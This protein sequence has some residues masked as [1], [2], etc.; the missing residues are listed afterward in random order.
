MG[1]LLLAVHVGRTVAKATDGCLAGAAA[2]RDAND[3]AR[4]R[5]RIALGCPC[6]DFDGLS[7]ATGHASYVGCASALVRDAADGTPILGLFGLRRPCRGTLTRIVRQSDCGYPAAEER[8]PCC[9]H[10]LDTGKN[11]GAIRRTLRCRPLKRVLQHVCE[12]T[13]FVADACSDDAT[14]SCSPTCGD[15]IRNGAEQCDGRDDAL[16]PGLCGRDCRCPQV[17][18][19]T[20]TIPSAAQPPHT[21]G[22]PGVTVTNPRLLAQFGGPSF[23]LNNSTY[24]RYRMNRPVQTADAVLILIP[25]FEGGAGE[26]KILAENLIPRTLGDGLVLEVWGFDRRTHQL[27]DRA[28]LDTAEDFLAAQVGLDWLFGAELGLALHPAL[29]AGSNR[30][31]VFY[32][33][34]ADVPFV[35]TWTNLVFSRD[36]DAVVAAAGAAVRNQNVFLGGHSFG[37]GFAARYAATDFN[38]TGVGAPD[39]GYTRLRGLVLLEGAAGSTAGPPLNADSLDRI[40]A[41]YDGGLFGAVRDN[42]AHCVDGVTACTI[43]NELVECAGQVPPKCT[44]PQPA[45]ATSSVLNPRILASVEVVGIQ[46]VTDPDGGQVILQVDQGVSGNR[47]VTKVPDLAFLNNMT[48]FPPATVEGAIGSL[49]D[50][51]GLLSEM[52]LGSPGAIVKGLL[53]WHDIIEGPLPASVLPDNGPPPT[54]LPGVRWGQEKEV[55]RFDRL[56]TTFFTGGTNFTDWYYPTAGLSTTSAPGVCTAGTC[57]A[58]NVGAACSAAADCAQTIDLDSTALSVGRGRR[59]IEN[60]TQAGNMDIPVICFG[61]SNGLLTPVPG[62]FVPFASSIGPCTAPSCDGTPRIVE[63]TIP[64]P[65]FP[66]FG[67]VNGG[68]EVYIS[69]GFAHLDLITAEDGADNNVLAPLAAFLERNVQ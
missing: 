56:L 22:S 44:L 63:T 15:G 67:G 60:L 54:S 40:V 53:T 45:Y 35:A 42:V 48:L 7:Q 68:F 69:E 27:E 52:S 25:G 66:T 3:I 16:C 51:E 49:L 11:A 62:R 18:Q 1:L 33:A 28:G 55:T 46:G 24:T 64:N 41:Q 43:L 34:H 26:F 23:S 17:V 14:N 37:T 2:A 50:D 31:A 57:T 65:A 20:M 36:L 5:G 4:L 61:A 47:A 38:L 29:V 8:H 21:P 59:D 6:S 39:P 13:H 9:R 58:G 12:A 10:R 32:D 30:Q 19:T